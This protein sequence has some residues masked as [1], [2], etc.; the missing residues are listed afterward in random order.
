MK[1]SVELIHDYPYPAERLWHVV[2][3]F[4]FLEEVVAGVISFRGLPKGKVALGQKIEVGVSLF[5]VLPYQPYEME[6]LALD[7]QNYTFHSLEKGAGVRAWEHHLKV[8]NTANGS[9]LVEKIVIDAGLLTPI[10]KLWA[11]FLYKKRHIPRLDILKRITKGTA[12]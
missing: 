7:S 12:A 8:E 10:F 1:Q 3:D 2:T 11:T 5:G 4:G 6:L 9:R